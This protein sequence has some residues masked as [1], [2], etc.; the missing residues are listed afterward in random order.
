LKASPVAAAKAALRLEMGRV[1]RAIPADERLRKAGLIA[2]SVLSLP[3]IRDVTVVLGFSSFGSEVPTSELLR[4]FDDAGVT[5]LLPFLDSGEMFVTPHRTGDRLVKS[6]YGP[7]EPV[8]RRP[9][10]LSR[11]QVVIVPGIAYDR[12][13]GRLGY[14]GGFYD[15]FLPQLPAAT[16]LV[17]IA[18]AEQIVAEVPRSGDDIK[19]ELVVT[20]LEVIR[21]RPPA[22]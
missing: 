13:G 3:E 1:R 21:S 12:A 18:F 14:G 5:V 15:R 22:G 16:L 19:V 10:E 4:A 2:S 17:G 8:L 20:D 6:S 11:I 9:F 7:L